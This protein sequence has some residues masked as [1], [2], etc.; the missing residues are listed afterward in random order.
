MN[1]ELVK[2]VLNV[3]EAQPF[4]FVKLRGR[5]IAH[6]VQ[7]MESAG[8]VELSAAQTKDPD[9][10][11]IKAVTDAGRRLLR[12]LR[13]KRTTRYLNRARA[14]YGWPSIDLEVALL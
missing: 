13:E 6:E 1:L 4:G 7:E 9:L 12:I 10:V 11:V 3:S 5:K 14:S 2:K 8:L